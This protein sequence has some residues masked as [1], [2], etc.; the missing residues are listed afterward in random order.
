[1]EDFENDWLMMFDADLYHD[2]VHVHDY[3]SYL[4]HFGYGLYVPERQI[5]SRY[6]IFQVNISHGQ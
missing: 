3:G 6:A 2:H 4:V 1:M 5:F